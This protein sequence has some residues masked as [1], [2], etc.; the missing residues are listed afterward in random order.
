MIGKVTYVSGHRESRLLQ[1]IYET[2]VLPTGEEQT[3]KY[4]T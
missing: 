3:H 2:W 4:T 1:D